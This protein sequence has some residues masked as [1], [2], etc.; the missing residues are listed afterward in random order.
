[1]PRQRWQ[2]GIPHYASRTGAASKSQVLPKQLNNTD[3]LSAYQ[4]AQYPCVPIDR[5]AIW[6]IHRMAQRYALRRR[7]HR[8]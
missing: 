6:R 4:V 8:S 3:N 5:L 1:L 7:T 2:K